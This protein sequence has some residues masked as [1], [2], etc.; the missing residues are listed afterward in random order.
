MARRYLAAIAL[1]C[2]LSLCAAT[3]RAPSSLTPARRARVFATIP[4]RN[5]ASTTKLCKI[6]DDD[7]TFYIDVRTSGEVERPPFL[8]RQF[9]HLPVAIPD[10][11]KD[12]EDGI[13][14]G[15]IPNDKSTPIV[16]F[17]GWVGLRANFA[18]KALVKKGYTEVVNGGG[19]RDV[20]DAC[21]ER[22]Q[23]QK[24]RDFFSTMGH[25]VFEFQ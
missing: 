15:V 11:S 25:G 19:I 7:R 4:D 14:S 12:I 13:K 23:G 21:G 22:T 8:R 17:S 24:I 16:V 2:A 18:K 9:V 3:Q 20:L 10:S 1:I 6:V 5:V